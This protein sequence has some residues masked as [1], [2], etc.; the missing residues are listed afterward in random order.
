MKPLHFKIP[1]LGQAAFIFDRGQ[2]EWYPGGLAF[3]SNLKA[4]LF[5]L[6]KYEGTKDLGAGLVTNLGVL[7]LANDFA[8]TVTNAPHNLFRSLKYHASGT[9]V[10]GAAATDI[11]LQAASGF[12]GQTPVAGT[13]VLVSAAN[14]QKYQSVAT[15]AYTGV[16]A[17]TEWGFFAYDFS[18][19][20]NTVLTDATMSPLTGTQTATSA[21]VTGTMTA[22]SATVQGQI[23]SI[24]ENTNATRVSWGLVTANTTSVVTIPAW[25]KTADGT[26]GTTGVAA[27]TFVFRPPMWDHKVFSP[28]N[29]ASG[30][31]IQFTYALT[32]S[33]GG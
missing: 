22:S 17:V 30:D 15:I 2:T 4:S 27:D 12:G 26:A 20:A 6:G 32:I 3:R 14:L 7:V 8:Q 13:Q 29:V 24:I 19:P 25:Y 9:G 31:S 1:F 21:T 33:S 18:L 28:I 23:M 16:E 10:T 11:K 5:H